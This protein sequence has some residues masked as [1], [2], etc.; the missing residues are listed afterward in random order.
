MTVDS[1][2]GPVNSFNRV[3]TAILPEVIAWHARQTG[4]FQEA[5]MLGTTIRQF[6]DRAEVWTRQMALI[7]DLIRDLEMKSCGGT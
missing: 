4:L 7:V 5:E 1:G 6:L 2:K 3:D